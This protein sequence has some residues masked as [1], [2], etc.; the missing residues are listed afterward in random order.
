MSS[1]PILE[2]RDLTVEYAMARGSVGAVDH[3]SFDLSAGEFLG[4]VGE[5]GCGKSHAAVRH[6]ATAHA[7]RRDHR[8]QRHFKGRNLVGLTDR[9]LAAT[10]WQDLSVVMQSAMNAFNPVKT[11]GAQFKD[12]IQAHD[13]WSGRPHPAALRR[14]ARSWSASTRCT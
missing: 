11:I 5:S 3:V 14:G 9:Q 13:K 6:R 10:R 7:A 8:G 2:V 4:I 12:A 1:A